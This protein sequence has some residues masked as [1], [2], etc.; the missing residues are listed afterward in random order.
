MS[1]A[2]ATT[3]RDTFGSATCRTCSHVYHRSDPDR[4]VFLQGLHDCDAL[5]L[6]VFLT[7]Q[8]TTPAVS[9]FLNFLAGRENRG[10]TV[11]TSQFDPEGWYKSLQDAVVAESILNRIVSTSALIQL[12][13]SNMRRHSRARVEGNTT[14]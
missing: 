7:T 9:E 6:N 2:G 4:L 3:P 1:P 14:S 11:V 5:F 13:G 8:I 12:D 10:A